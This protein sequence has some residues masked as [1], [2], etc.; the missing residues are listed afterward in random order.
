MKKFRMVPA[1]FTL[2]AGFVAS[3]IMIMHNYSLVPFLWIL[4][5]VMVSFYLASLIVCR[6]LNVY[7]MEKIEEEYEEND[8]YE[9]ED[10]ENGDNIDEE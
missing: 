5:G 6:I 7:F 10:G 9:S 3:V 2:L 1:I 8:D 4:V